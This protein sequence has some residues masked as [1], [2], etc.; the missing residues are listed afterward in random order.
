LF[1]SSLLWGER[2]LRS[3]ANLTRQDAAEYLA[4]ASRLS[5]HAHFRCWPLDAANDAVR[6]LRAGI[7]GCAVLVVHGD[8]APCAPQD[9]GNA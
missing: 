7:A 3:L 2:T 8:G 6:S 5:V 9:P 4:L 1:P